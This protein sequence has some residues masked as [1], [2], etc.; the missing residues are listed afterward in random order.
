VS[1][2]QRDWAK[3]LDV[4]QLSYNLQMSESTGQ[5]PFEIVTG[6]QPLNPSSLAKGYKGPSPPAYKFVKDWNDQV[7]AARGVQK[8]PKSKTE[9]KN[10]KN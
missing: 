7:G 5:S 2:N 3:L 1:A 8:N 10:R 6:Q 4:A 9:P